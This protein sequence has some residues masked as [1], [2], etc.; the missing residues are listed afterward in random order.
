MTEKA[1]KI[2]IG[3]DHAGYKIKEF[4][5]EE[6]K[7]DNYIFD[8]IGVFSEES[9]DYPDI[10]HPMAEAVSQGKYKF[11]ILICGTGNGMAMAAN[12][13]KG[14]RA[15]LCWNLEITRLART[16]NNANI[17]TMPGR[18]IEYELAYEMVKVF[19]TTAFE[20]G[21]HIRRVDKINL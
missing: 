15:A 18:Y 21:R 3:T 20:G 16:H 9:M 1:H 2:I 13:H 6:L 7:K 8:D 19:L 14:V 12:R 5:K 10:A 4:I 17:L 11:G